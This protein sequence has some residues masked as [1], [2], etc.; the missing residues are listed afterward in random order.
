MGVPLRVGTGPGPVRVLY[1]DV[2]LSTVGEGVGGRW[3]SRG[4]ST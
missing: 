3:S 2:C 1:E 4:L